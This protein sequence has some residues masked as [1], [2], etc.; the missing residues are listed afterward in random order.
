MP[1]ATITQDLREF[2][3]VPGIE[4]VYLE[5]SDGETYQSKKF[6]VILG[7]IATPNEDADADLNVTFSGK[8]AT[9]NY[10]AQTDRNMTLVLFGRK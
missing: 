10:A 8:T 1:D 5:V 9:I 2:C 6:S 3:N 7:A 4:A